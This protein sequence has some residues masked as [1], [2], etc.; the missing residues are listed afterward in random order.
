MMGVAYVGMTTYIL[1]AKDTDMNSEAVRKTKPWIEGTPIQDVLD[2]FF[3]EDI[4]L[5][6][7]ARLETEREQQRQKLRIKMDKFMED[8]RRRQEIVNRIYRERSLIGPG[9]EE[10]KPRTERLYMHERP[11]DEEGRTP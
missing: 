2:Y 7:E 9:D 11:P 10:I 8:D 4:D 6:E 1:S 3:N 5:A